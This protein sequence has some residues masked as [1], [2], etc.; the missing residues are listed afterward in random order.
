MGTESGDKPHHGLHAALADIELQTRALAAK[1]ARLLAEAKATGA[2]N[3]TG[4]RT[5]AGYV[6]SICNTGTASSKRDQTLA[7]LVTDHPAVADALEAGHISV[8]A[9]HEISRFHVNPRIRHMLGAVL[10]TL[11]DR[12][13]ARAATAPGSP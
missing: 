1:R 5:V 13:L 7:N 8:D 12:S 10:D 9:A 11:L 6:R 4:H 2:H 3:E